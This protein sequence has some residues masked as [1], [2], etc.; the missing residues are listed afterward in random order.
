M[1]VGIIA[2]GPTDQRVI[3]AIVKGVMKGGEGAPNELLV[4]DVRPEAGGPG[5]WGLVFHA[6]RQR[7]HEEALQQNDYLVIQIDTDVCDQAG[8]DVPR[9]GHDEAGLIAQVVARLQR[10]MSP[11][12]IERHGHRVAFAIAV[13]SLEC[14]LL[15]LIYDND[16]AR[17]T[18]NCL[19]LATEGLRNR[20][21]KNAGL[22]Q[23]DEKFVRAYIAAA[24]PFM[25]PKQLRA[26]CVRSSSLA[27]FV[28]QL[29][30]LA[31]A[32]RLGPPPISMP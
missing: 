13:D 28:A 14:W 1:R 23:G 22:H 19:Y 9:V 24:R 7:Q 30:G 21:G 3:E 5:G 2:E 12:F 27:A 4:H 16:R 18:T 29:D 8:F 26:A 6:L 11:E 25:K 15:P 17:R 32:H 20:D 10:E 31:A